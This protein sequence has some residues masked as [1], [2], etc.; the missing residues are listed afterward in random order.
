[1]YPEYE[2]YGKKKKCEEV[3]IS[4]PTQHQNQQPGLETLMVPRP[5]SENS[6]A[7]GSGK[8]KD[9]VTIITG[10]DS[11]IGRAVAYAFAKEGAD[12]VIAYLNE[13]EDAEETR[14]RVEQY[15][16]RC[17][18]VPGDLQQEAMS[19]E[20]VRQAIQHFD[21]IDILVNN[22]AVQFVQQSILDITAEQLDLTFRTNIYAF[23]FMTKAV[24][25]H[26]KS[27]SAIINTTSVTAYAGNPQL[28]DYSSTKGAILAF[29]RS[30]SQSL[31]KQGIRVN[32]VAPGPI[33]TPLI[34]ATFPEEQVKTFGTDTPMK[35][36]GQPFEVAT[37]YVFLAS[38]DSRY[39]T[40]QILHPNGGELVDS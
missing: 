19:Q 22:H 32:G 20:V 21:K 38:D 34:P 24:L 2:Y 23:F 17:L 9:K 25:P 36:A 29:T 37:S 15:G 6:E 3:P 7:L 16:R 31:V 14:Q 33:W 8:L 5:I 12:V 35:R 40:G 30:L 27:G 1:M 18:L 11:G 28:L 4:F 26:L 13:H 10:G 39:I